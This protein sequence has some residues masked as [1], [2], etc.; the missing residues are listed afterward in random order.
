[1]TTL[2][3]GGPRKTHVIPLFLFL[4]FLLT[5]PFW[6]FSLE[7]GSFSDLITIRLSDDSAPQR[8]PAARF[9]HDKHT[10]A[11]ADKGCAECHPAEKEKFVFKFKRAKDAG[12]EAEKKMYHDNCIGCH[13]ERNDRRETAGPMASDCRLCHGRDSEY[14]SS[15]LPFGMDKSLH[16]RHEISP[17]IPLTP[18][19]ANGQENEKDWRCGR[20]HHEYDPTLEK[21]IYVKGKESTC[22]Y[23][24]L[25]EN[26][27]TARSFQAVAHED[28]INCHLSLKTK[29]KK[30]GPQEC[31]GCHSAEKQSQIEIIKEIPRIR[32][33][34][35]DSAL[36][37]LWLAETV[38]S[39]SPSPRFMEAVAFDHKTHEAK[40]DHCYTCHHA[41]MESCGKCH[42]RTGTEK[43]KYTRLETAMHKSGSMTSCLGCHETRMTDKNCAGCHARMKNQS[44]SDNNCGK[45]HSVEKDTLLPVP[46]DEQAPKELADT[47]ITARK[48]APPIKLE[49]SIPEKDIPENVTISIMK[50]TYEGAT[51]PHRKIVN[52][53]AER[54]GEN[55]L[56]AHFHD[57]AKTL[58]AG[59]HHHSPVSLTPPACA[60]CHGLH[61]LA[62]SAAEPDGRPGL[63]GAYHGQ[64]IRCHQE[65]GIEKPAATDC[66]AC[67][68][69]KE[70]TAKLSLQVSE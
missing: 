27:E 1:M 46:A 23:C 50:N 20:C 34:Q 18:I 38:E 61:P 30:T 16:F 42:T 45:C 41:S 15:A 54:I 19:Q 44:F 43:S 47:S 14:Q 60:S 25:A 24:H 66:T 3:S 2:P 51:F 49:N 56:A 6:A 12:Y 26:T 10:K 69:L 13:Q 21:T 9:L 35:P 36:L 62:D 37:S 32:R 52:S 29:N 65:M 4:L 11:L 63:K 57:D 31:A 17:S 22:R 59:C 40:T 68:Q 48:A 58:C 53:L 33:N 39:G 64:C 7:T 5:I 8:M 70:T 28:C 67:H 55:R